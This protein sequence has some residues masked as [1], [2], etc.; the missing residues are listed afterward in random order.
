M[1]NTLENCLQITTV[2]YMP[3]ALISAESLERI[4]AVA[5][6]FPNELSAF[7]GFECRLGEKHPRADFSICIKQTEGGGEK[8]AGTHPSVSLPEPILDHPVWKLVKKFAVSWADPRSP[9]SEN[10]SNLWL[11]FDLSG[12]VNDLPVPSVFCGT[13]GIG[14]GS[15]NPLQD[16][17]WVTGEALPVLSGRRVSARV[18]E[19]VHSCFSLLPG[20]SYVFQ[21][22][23]MLARKVDAVR[24]CIRDIS[25]EQILEYLARIGWSDS[26]NEIEPTLARLA[27]LVDRIDLDLDI[28]ERVEPKIGLECYFTRKHDLEAGRDSFLGFLAES[29]LCTSDKRHALGKYGGIVFARNAG[30]QWPGNLQRL[31]GMLRG[32]Y[33]STYLRWIHHIKVVYTPGRET[34]AK[35]YLAVRHFWIENAQVLKMYQE[36]KHAKT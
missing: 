36:M 18:R 26:G 1:N 19:N 5:R 11:E 23:V 32:S 17:V 13:N 14:P 35:A 22:G 3:Q 27:A 29:G 25:P 4:A 2:P 33:E 16:P 7:F 21:I 20:K 15:S 6:F 31:A 30:S 10:V 28:A 8:L 24:I 34:A 9:L 12:P